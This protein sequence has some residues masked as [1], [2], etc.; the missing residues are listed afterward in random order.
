MSS[1]AHE[2][3]P[4]GADPTDEIEITESREHIIAN[5]NLCV[6]VCLWLGVGTILTVVVAI[7][8][9]NMWGHIIVALAIAVAKATLVVL[10]FM[11]FLHEKITIKQTMLITAIFAFVLFALT[12]LAWWD[13][14]MLPFDI[15]GAPAGEKIAVPHSE[16]G[17]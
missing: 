2:P 10:F 17:H 8:P 14:P 7:I 5:R 15:Y 4:A 12:L 1:H 3:L 11:H 16:T 9:F 13:P 6:K